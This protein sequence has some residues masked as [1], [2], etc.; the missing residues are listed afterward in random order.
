[1][2]T[3][4]WFDEAPTALAG[5]IDHKEQRNAIAAQNLSAAIVQSAQSLPRMPFLFRLDLV[6]G[7]RE[8]VVHPDY[9]VVA[10]WGGR[11]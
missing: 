8:H 9:I 2:Q 6:P 10:G 4:W 5:I 7:N 1:M 11:D 3:V